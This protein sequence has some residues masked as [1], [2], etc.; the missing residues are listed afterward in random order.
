MSVLVGGSSSASLKRSQGM[1]NTGAMSGGG[2]GLNIE[3][4]FP[5]GRGPA[6]LGQKAEKSLQ[7]SIRI[8]TELNVEASILR[9][10][11]RRWD[12]PWRQHELKYNFREVVKCSPVAN[13][14]MEANDKVNVGRGS[15]LQ[16]SYPY[17]EIKQFSDFEM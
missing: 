7:Q 13:Q 14:W 12:W 15:C 5:E 16:K 6:R 1:T 10:F 4:P 9:I 11:Q 2:S 3:V 8:V 17:I